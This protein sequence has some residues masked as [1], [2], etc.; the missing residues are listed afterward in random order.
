[1]CVMIV[2]A[3][4]D[5]EVLGCGGTI[6]K[7]VDANHDVHIA[8][9]GEGVTSRYDQ[10]ESADPSLVDDLQSCSMQVAKLLGARSVRCLGLPDNRFDTVALLDVVKHIE[11]LIEEFRPS[12]IYTH[13]PGDLNIDHAITF[14]AVLTA[15]RPTT[16][17]SVRE[18]FAFEV[19]SATDWA[20]NQFRPF[21]PNVFTD[22]SGT[23]EAKLTALKLYES[24]VRSFP[25]P[26][27]FEALRATAQRWGSIA[28]YDYAEAFE[29]VRSLRS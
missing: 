18:I 12:I 8:I 13:H 28:G 2:A 19:A 11:R 3:H 17:S 10:P 22:V 9:M 15:T 4:P 7:L 27:S 6:P 24:E 25:H 14:R 21:R 23:I 29:L 1:M 16:G 20:F 5:D 26:R